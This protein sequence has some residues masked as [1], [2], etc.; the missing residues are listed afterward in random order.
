MTP[1]MYAVKD[2][3][4]GLLD[5]M[6]E[7]GADVGARNNASI[8][9]KRLST[10]PLTAINFSYLPF[11]TKH[12]RDSFVILIYKTLV[13]N[14]S[15]SFFFFSFVVIAIV[16]VILAY[17]K[18]KRFRRKIIAI[19]LLIIKLASRCVAATRNVARAAC[20]RRARACTLR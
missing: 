19:V 14:F 12:I 5:R 13:L 4:T 17:V 16:I 3:R 10:E 1:L 8:S 2:N 18:R 9:K 7:L 20:I 6:I 15:S 11:C